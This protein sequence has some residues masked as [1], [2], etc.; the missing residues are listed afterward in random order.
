LHIRN[1]FSERIFHPIL[2]RH[3]ISEKRKTNQKKLVE[4]LSE[5]GVDVEMNKIA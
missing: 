5:L 4:R 2:K 3:N 1:N